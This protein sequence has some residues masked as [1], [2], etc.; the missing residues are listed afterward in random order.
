MKARNKLGCAV[1]VW[2]FTLSAAAEEP[3]ISNAK[4][5]KRSAAAGL[6][7]EFRALVS[8]E[9]EPAWIGYEVPMIAGEHRMCCYNSWSDDA[10]AGCCGGCRLEG[11]R[12]GVTE[13]SVSRPVELESSGKL[14]VLF[15]LEQKRVG[16]IR[17]F[18]GDC[19]LDAGGL[20]FILLTEVRP[21]ESVALLAPFVA[22]G[23]DQTPESKQPA[24]GALTAIAFHAD[25]AAD[26]AIEQFV[27]PS[28]PEKLRERATFWLGA[29][30]GR[31][32][33]EILRRIVREDPSDRVRDR[34]VFAL[35]VSQE[36]EAVDTMIAVAHDDRSSHLRGQALFWLAH[37][38]G[39]KA[40]S[41]IT[42]AI[43]N[44]PETAVKKRAVFALSQLPKDEGVPMLIQVARTNQNPAVRRQAMFWLGQSKDSRA[45]AFF[46]E[47]LKRSN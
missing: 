13:G 35:S 17:T 32:G 16:K 10:G 3:H 38:A 36:P 44:D 45:L 7:K 26:H 12:D 27:A 4:L 23:A 1:L 14:L 30:R 28:S 47:V 8:G 20:P 5:Q 22:E 18:S 37:K 40:S 9:T 33:Y 11:T 43:E 34:A 15:R 19:D 2:F 46:E 31:R 25:P 39:R 41:A 42:E 29:A 6:E 21:A 24:R